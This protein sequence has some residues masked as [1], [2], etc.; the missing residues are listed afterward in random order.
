MRKPLG[1]SLYYMNLPVLELPWYSQGLKF[2]CS[3][4]GNCCSGS[5]GFVW[6]SAE[7]IERLAEFLKI[8]AKSVIRKYCRKIGRQYSLT[9]NRHPQHGGFDCVFVKELP[10]EGNSAHPRRI[11]SVYEVRPLQC[12]TWPFWE[13]NLASSNAW[14]RAARNCKGMNQ[15]QNFDR[16]RIESLR[17]AT[18]WPEKPPTSE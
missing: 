5:P 13:G 12:R 9:E 8:S 11:C 16:I 2:T 14:D 7:E 6:V 15:G 17:D 10:P 4:C 3:Q 1:I 18:D